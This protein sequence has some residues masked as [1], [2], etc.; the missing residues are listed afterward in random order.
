MSTVQIPD[1]GLPGAG[2]RLIDNSF[3]ATSTLARW[4]L[5]INRAVRKLESG[6]NGNGAD[7]AQAE[8]DA[9]TGIANAAAAQATANAALPKAGGTVT[10][11]LVMSGAAAAFTVASMTTAQKNALTAANGMIVYDTTLGKFQGR[12]AGAWVNLV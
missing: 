3:R 10:G 1:T 9:Q 7:A 8:A 12:E 2:D 5:N 11:A 6:T 4:M